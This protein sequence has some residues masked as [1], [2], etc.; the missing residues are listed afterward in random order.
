MSIKLKNID[1]SSNKIWYN[2]V[3]S[4]RI[5]KYFNFQSKFFIEYSVDI[6]SVP[7][8]ILVIPF[9]ANVLPIAW[10]L[11]EEIIISEVD[12]D[13]YNSI[14]EFKKGYIKMYPMINFS[15]SLQVHS[16]IKNIQI[17]KKNSEKTL[18]FF[19]GG[20]DSLNT[21]IQHR[22]EYP[23]LLSIWGSDVALD[24]IDGWNKISRLIDSTAQYFELQ[25]Q[26][27]KSSFRYFLNENSL[28][29]KIAKTGD[30]WWHG[31]QHGIGI[32]S[33][34]A[35]IAWLYNSPKCY[36][37]SSFSSK[38]PIELPCA[39]HPN[40]DGKVRFSCTQIIHDGFEQSRQDKIDTIVLFKNMTNNDIK[41]HVCWQTTG[42]RNCNK[43]EKCL[44]TILGIITSGANPEDFGFH[45]DVKYMKNLKKI[46][47]RRINNISYLLMLYNYLSTQKAFKKNNIAKKYREL[48]WFNDIKI[49]EYMLESKHPSTIFK[50]TNIYYTIKYY[51]LKILSKTYKKCRNT[52]VKN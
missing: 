12:E 34:A 23:I 50:I 48:K 40:I 10:V 33:H 1:K 52:L 5:K 42:G 51:M 17:E 29:Q 37:S 6:S 25:S 15:G 7:N 32:V 43:C 18:C 45:Y 44:R 13:F 4:S 26:K 39:S 47:N 11:N 20:V 30:G 14:A 36:F 49:E 35:P 9:L 41:L 3:V 21:L 22:N 8:S 38:D 24:D 2:F 46:L 27:I 16:V 28:S 19:S 31:F